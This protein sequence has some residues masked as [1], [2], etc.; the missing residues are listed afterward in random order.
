MRAFAVNGGMGDFGGTPKGTPPRAPLE[1]SLDGNHPPTRAQLRTT[2]VAVVVGGAV[3]LA[4]FSGWVPG[5][6]PS[7]GQPTTV[8]FEGKTYYW[9]EVL[10]PTPI[11][12]TGSTPPQ[13]DLFHNATFWFWGVADPID[14]TRYLEGNVSLDG[15]PVYSFTLGGP[16]N[17][18][19]WVGAF[20]TPGGAV[21]VLWPAGEFSAQFL[22][23]T[24]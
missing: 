12:G 9:S 3:G 2:V 23:V 14:S 1:A 19:T 8:A 18:A 5:L 16:P 7:F 6:H 15:G 17:P 21:V 4:V 13:K 24:T 22:V 11:P 20:S 10:V